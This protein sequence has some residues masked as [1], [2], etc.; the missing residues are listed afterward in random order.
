MVCILI[1][2]EGSRMPNKVMG[3]LNMPGTVYLDESPK[4]HLAFGMT[5]SSIFRTLGH[6]LIGYT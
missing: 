1:A 2:D 5:I 3:H 4:L 6:K